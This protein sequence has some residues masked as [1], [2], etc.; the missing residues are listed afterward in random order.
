MRLI[1]AD[2]VY[3]NLIMSGPC[4]TASTELNSFI[5]QY[6]IQLMLFK[7]GIIEERLCKV[8]GIPTFNMEQFCVPKVASHDPIK[9]VRAHYNYITLNFMDKVRNVL[10]NRKECS[11]SC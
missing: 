1:I 10:R 5:K 11:N 9:E 3:I 7:G 2:V 4:Y 8:A 6:N